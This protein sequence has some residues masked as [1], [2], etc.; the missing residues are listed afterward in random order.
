MITIRTPFTDSV[1][2]GI[3]AVALAIFLS[4]NAWLFVD[5]WEKKAELEKREREET[6]QYERIP[7]K[8]R[9]RL[10]NIR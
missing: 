1:E 6:A 5:W 4:A 3:L 8:L 10:V 7:E 2:R 9:G